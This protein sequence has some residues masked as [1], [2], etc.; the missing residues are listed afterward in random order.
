MLHPPTPARERILLYGLAGTGK[1]HAWCKIREWYEKTGCEG[2]VHILDTDVAVERMALGWENFYSNSKVVDAGGWQELLSGMEGF[3]GDRGKNDWLVVDMIDK[4]WTYA[5]AG[6]SEQVTGKRLD[7]WFLEAKKK[8]ESIGGD[9]GINWGII[10]RMYGHFM[11]QVM[12][13]QGHVLAC[14]PGDKVMDTEDQE[15]KTTYSKF[16]YKPAG[17]KALDHQ[18]HTVIYCM[19]TGKE[20]KMT[21]V[22]DRNRE[23]MKGKVIHDFVMDYL[24]PVGKWMP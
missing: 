8:G 2:T 21:T 1:S 15:T 7:Q 19:N 5:Q 13:F 20:W 22:K 4:A 10:N 24:I 18:F 9:Y 17:Q 12:R 11:S 23:P 16:G 3:K 6:F 14:A